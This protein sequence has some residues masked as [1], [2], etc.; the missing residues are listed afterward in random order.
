MRLFE[1]SDIKNFMHNLFLSPLFDELELRQITICTKSTFSIEGKINKN[2]LSLEET[3]VLDSEYIKWKEL[4]E[5]SA[6]FIKGSRPPSFIK[7][8]FS[9][10]PL[11]REKI[12]P[13]ASALFLNITYSEKSLSCTTGVSLKNFSLDKKADLIWDEYIHNFLIKNKLI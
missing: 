12:L 5:T 7:A 8:V 11:K 4:R 9:V 2:Y 1:I 3:E 10:S 13:E 6:G